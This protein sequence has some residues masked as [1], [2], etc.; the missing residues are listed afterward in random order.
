[1]LVR[2]HERF[3]RDGDDLVTVADVPA[4]L[5]ALGS[6]LEIEGLD[7][8][9]I[10]LEIPA[11][12]QPGETLTVR[13][14]G[15]PGL[16]R[17]GRSGDLRAVVNVQIPRKLDRHQRALLKELAESVRPEQLGDGESLVGRLRR[18]LQ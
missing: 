9:T 3:L 11:G 4:P 17:R 5:A 12:T 10:E 7:G 18:L 16:Q 8:T 2:P 1:V 14:A 15:L 6:K 13:G